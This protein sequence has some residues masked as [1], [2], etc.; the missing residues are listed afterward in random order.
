[1]PPRTFWPQGLRSPPVKTHPGPRAG[2]GRRSR[3]QQETARN[4]CT[5]PQP[6]PPQHERVGIPRL[7]PWG[8]RQDGPQWQDQDRTRQG[9]PGSG[10]A[11]QSPLRH[12]RLQLNRPYVPGESAAEQKQ[13]AE[14]WRWGT[15]RRPGFVRDRRL[16][17]RCGRPP[18]ISS[19]A[20]LR[21]A[22]ICCLPHKSR[23][24]S[25]PVSG[26]AGSGFCSSLHR[27]LPRSWPRSGGRC[28]RGRI[29]VRAAGTWGMCGPGSTGLES[30]NPTLPL[31]LAGVMVPPATAGA[32]LRWAAPS[33]AHLPGR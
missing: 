9:V 30:S 33:A 10:R 20:A 15:A 12:C 26:S 19:T 7:Q 4:Y 17:E 5:N 18:S 14:G 24:T 11:D 29:I 25:S 32:L 8:G 16:H 31:I 2:H 13:A 23:C 6:L 22:T 27:C 28:C 21:P 3:N 1:M